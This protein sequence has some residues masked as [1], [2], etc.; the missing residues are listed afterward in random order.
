M[1]VIGYLVLGILGL[2]LG[3]IG[4]LQ[5]NYVLAGLGAVLIFAGFFW[6]VRTG[7]GSPAPGREDGSLPNH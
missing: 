7:Q 4:V 2:V 5:T 3:L 6:F 1:S